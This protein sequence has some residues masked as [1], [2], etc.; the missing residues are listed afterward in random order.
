MGI[1]KVAD[2]GVGAGGGDLCFTRRHRAILY[3]R[4]RSRILRGIGTVFVRGEVGSG[5]LIPTMN[6]GPP[7]RR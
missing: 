1:G 5:A 3:R 7:A 6:G 4:L 2:A